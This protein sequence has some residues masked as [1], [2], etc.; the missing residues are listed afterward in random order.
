[1]AGISSIGAGS[2][3]LTS[4]LIEKLVNS[5]RAPTELR[6]D[7]K[8][9]SLQA[10]LSGY[11][12][13]QSA[14]TDLRLP[15]RTLSLESAI[16]QLEG[17]STNSAI[18]V[19]AGSG[20]KSGQYTMEVGQL[21]QAHSVKSASPYVTKD[22]VIGSGT[23]SFTVGGKTTAI[24]L[25]ATNNTLEGIVDSVNSQE[26]LAVNADL[27]QVD[28]GFQLVFSSKESGLD[29]AI[30]ISVSGDADGDPDIGLSQLAYSGVNTATMSEAVAAK[31]AEFSINGVD[32]TRASNT[33]DDAIEGLTFT[34][35]DTTSAPATVRVQPN[36]DKVAE[37]IQAFVDSY[38]AFKE[39]VNELS[40]YD[41]T[42]ESGV[43][44]G[45]STL[46]NVDAQ[47]R[48]VIANGVAGLGSSRIGS[49]AE[50]GIS[51]NKDTGELE[52][53]TDAFAKVF[54]DNIDDIS[55]LFATQ[56]RASDPQIKFEGYTAATVAGSYQVEVTSLATH[57]EL[58]ALAN[59]A[60]P[61]N[62]VIDSDNDTFTISIDGQSSG[63]ISLDQNGGIAYTAAD[64]AQEMEDKINA[65]SALSA[66]G[67]SAS[68]SFDTL[69]GTFVIE[70]N[71]Y[72]T[73][74]TVELTQVGA[75]SEATLGL[76][77]V[78][79]TAGEDIKGKIN[80]VEAVGDGQLL[81]AA[82]GI[83]AEGIK[84][85]ITGGATGDRGTA[86]YIT[87]IGRRLVDTITNL[88]S[89]DGSLSTRQEGL[90]ESLRG[91]DDERQSLDDRLT[92]FEARLAKQFTAADI[93]IGQ[94][95]STEDFVKSQLQALS[96]NNDK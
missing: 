27:I 87:G 4:D 10:E 1:M 24:T 57:G 3:V 41:S 42:G 78:A 85:L 8:E 13:L 37:E 63:V 70:S 11:G 89:I 15:S 65:D 92:T 12:R 84:L 39:I 6:L 14:L 50:I 23:L 19:R 67:L 91:L 22:E 21:A 76:T 79:G 72:G 51:T 44:L 69:S 9:E 71:S 45:D 86:T 82:S 93:L 5:E 61:N 25:D 29:N 46:R 77:A 30:E 48:N 88:V 60:D 28:G 35:T 68:V 53:D 83:D 2:G 96:G 47:V 52:F 49:M 36:V 90:R 73:D 16:K 58:T 81:K 43:L 59:V 62:I 55:A 94:L 66:K 32:V 17:S 18:D 95:K 54:A 64:L 31:N 34:L 20:A 56:G 40:V 74:S 38:N 80:G 26:G 75:Q 33:I 7:R